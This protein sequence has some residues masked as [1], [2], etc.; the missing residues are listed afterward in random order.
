MTGGSGPSTAAAKVGARGLEGEA[1]PRAAPAVPGR[2]RG[3]QQVELKSKSPWGI[4]EQC[5]S[6]TLPGG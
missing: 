4:T 1:G 2:E 5:P 6:E 3:R